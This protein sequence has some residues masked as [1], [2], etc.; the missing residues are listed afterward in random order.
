[1]LRSAFVGSRLVRTKRPL[2]AVDQNLAFKRLVQDASRPGGVRAL[3]T[4]GCGN[5]VM[6][7]IGTRWPSAANR[8][9][10]SRPLMPGICTSDITHD[11]R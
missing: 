9:C 6:K 10:R 7:M 4:L 8:L 1:M 5:A 3:S 11:D 2:N